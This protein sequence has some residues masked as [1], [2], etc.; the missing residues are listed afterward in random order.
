MFTELSYVKDQLKRAPRTVWA[1]CAK[2]SGV[3]FRTISRIVYGETMPGS[4]TV[5][6][7]AMYFRTKE[8]RKAA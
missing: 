6:K 5:G 8:K 3:H 7:I 2:A 4:D 1:E